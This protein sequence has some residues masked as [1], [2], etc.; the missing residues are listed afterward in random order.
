MP[1][2]MRTPG[3]PHNYSQPRQQHLPPP[4][5]EFPL[6]GVNGPGGIAGP[7]GENPRVRALELEI[8]ALR[9]YAED[10]RLRLEQRGEKVPPMPMPSYPIPG[11]T[12]GFSDGAMGVGHPMASGGGSFKRRRSGS[13]GS[14][15]DAGLFEV[16]KQ[17]ENHW[18]QD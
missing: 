17:V 10:L 12:R 4:T 1:T 16:S 5:P 11:G 18:N 9:E 15:S 2:P 3:G 13:R 8:V 6:P 14:L 7:I